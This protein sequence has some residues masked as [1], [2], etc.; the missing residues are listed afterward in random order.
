MFWHTKLTATVQKI[1]QEILPPEVAFA[2]DARDLLIECCVEFVTLISSEANEIAEREA[3]KT[4][5]ADHIQNA[6][7]DLGFNEYIDQIKEAADEHKETQ[8]VVCYAYH[9]CQGWTCKVPWANIIFLQTRERKHTKLEASGLTEE[10]LLRQQ[11]ELFGSARAKYDQG[12]SQQ[13]D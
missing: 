12:Q 11:E 7:I 9:S 3:K 10:E 13:S 2:K 5:G 6:L 8:K 1:I 4:I